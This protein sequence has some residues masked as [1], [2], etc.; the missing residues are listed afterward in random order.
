LA[1]GSLRFYLAE[2]LPVE[3]AR[4]L[5]SRGIDVVTVRSL[6]LLGDLDL[7]HLQRAT[8]MNCVLCTYDADFVALAASGIDHAGI[9]FGQADTHYIGAWVRYL[10][11]M[12]AI[13]TLDEMRNHVEYL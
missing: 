8:R 11:L 10:E 12:H 5:H 4:Q 9:V 7:N 6:N 3:I 2:N 1:T 13:Y